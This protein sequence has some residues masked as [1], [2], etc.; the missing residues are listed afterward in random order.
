[1]GSKE[2]NKIGRK[3]SDQGIDGVITFEDDSNG[4]PKRVIVQVKSGTVKSGD[5]RDPVSAR[6]R[7]NKRQ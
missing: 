1:V 4:G 2:R 5:I 6:F 7:G 3:G